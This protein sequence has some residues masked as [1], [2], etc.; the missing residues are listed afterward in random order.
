MYFFSFR[1]KPWLLTITTVTTF[2]YSIQLST[3]YITEVSYFCSVIIIEDGCSS[4]FLN[5]FETR[6]C[7]TKEIFPSQGRKWKI[8]LMDSPEFGTT[9]N[10]LGL[11]TG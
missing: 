8:C 9:E 3:I 5:A 7:P 1:D 6:H 10:P 4:L 11:G 2:H